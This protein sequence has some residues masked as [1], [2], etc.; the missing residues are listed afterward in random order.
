MQPAVMGPNLLS[1]LLIQ[2][3]YSGA[4]KVASNCA[5]NKDNFCWVRVTSPA[6]GYIK[7]FECSN[8]SVS[9]SCC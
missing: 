4:T 1:I 7:N 5:Y 3:Y 9:H 6:T 8:P 2:V